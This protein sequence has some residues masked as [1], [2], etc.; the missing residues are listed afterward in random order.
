MRMKRAYDV[1]TT[2]TRRDGSRTRLR[3]RHPAAL[4]NA[5]ITFTDESARPA[6][7]GRFCMSRQFRYR[8]TAVVLGGLLGGAPL[9]TN[10]TASAGQVEGGGRQVVFAGGMLGLTCRSTP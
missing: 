8:V 2:L 1:G 4:V 5:L 10:G 3:H 7:A 6:R 9:L